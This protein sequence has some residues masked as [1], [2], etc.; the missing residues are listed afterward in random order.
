M[1]ISDER[2]AA[3][4]ARIHIGMAAG[5]GFYV[6]GRELLPSEP[7]SDVLAG[8]LLLSLGP[9]PTPP[10]GVAF[11]VLA[12]VFITTSKGGE[13]LPSCRIEMNRIPSESSSKTCN[14]C[15]LVRLKK[16]CVH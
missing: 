16:I 6:E 13:S 7:S 12:T 5:D 14:F 8:L 11:R 15:V 9:V 10:L 1:I 3:E 2:K 4:V